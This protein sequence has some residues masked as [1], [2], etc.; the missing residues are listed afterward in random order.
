MNSK[1]PTI[2]WTTCHGRWSSL[3]GVNVV[4]NSATGEWSHVTGVGAYCRAKKQMLAS[5]RAW[6]NWPRA[7]PVSASQA[8]CSVGCNARV[9]LGATAVAAHC[10][11]HCLVIS[12]ATPEPLDSHGR[13]ICQFCILKAREVQHVR[14]I[15]CGICHVDQWESG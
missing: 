5:Q 7:L 3:V 8:P 13:C 2:E 14:E 4:L 1:H 11:Q 6:E 9:D 15:F 12:D 10:L